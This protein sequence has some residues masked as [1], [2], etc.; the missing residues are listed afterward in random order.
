[1]KKIIAG[2]AVAGSLFAGAYAF[3][4]NLSV[5]SNDLAA[6]TD[7]VNAC[8]TAAVATVT[9][10]TYDETSAEYV[11]D[12][13]TVTF[14]GA[15]D[16]CNGQTIEVTLDGPASAIDEGTATVSGSSAVVSIDDA[17]ADDVTRIA[18]VVTGDQPVAPQ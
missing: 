18:V 10:R 2:A 5:D 16:G 1:M 11:V 7:A 9:G 3:A 13:V 17:P 12:E 8:E 4:A 15:G 6:G 14:P